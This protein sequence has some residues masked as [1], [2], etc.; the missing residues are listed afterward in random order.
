MPDEET[1]PIKLN[2]IEDGEILLQLEIKE[3]EEVTLDLRDGTKIV[4]IGK[5]LPVNHRKALL[6]LLMKNKNVFAYSRGDMLGIESTFICHS[7]NV[8]KMML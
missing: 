4:F 2:E 7:L 3:T 5:N 1:T 6:E 8:N